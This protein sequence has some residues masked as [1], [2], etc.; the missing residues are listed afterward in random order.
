VRGS[1]SLTIPGGK[2]ITHREISLEM[3]DEFRTPSG[4]PLHR[5]VQ[6]VQHLLPAGDLMSGF[7]SDFCFDNLNFPT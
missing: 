7:T 1:L 3:F 6:R 4:T 5:Y 2:T